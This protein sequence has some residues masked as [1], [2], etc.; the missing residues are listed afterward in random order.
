LH[1]PPEEI[2]RR[3]RACR[4]GLEKAHWQVLWL[5]TRPGNPLSPA[6]AAPQ[7]GL[8]AVWVRTLIKRWN[9]QGPDGLAD[10][11]AATN[12]GHCKLSTDQQ[13]DLWGALQHPPPDGGL[14][15]GSKVAAYVRDRWGVS[16]C[17]QTGWNWLRGLGFSLR[18]PRPRHPEAA[19]PAQ[20]RAWE[21]RPGPPARPVASAAS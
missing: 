7:V 15:T 18:V 2:A 16:L 4:S 21:R 11:R 12:G 17:V 8:S 5:V 1:L 9:A 3:Y 6:Q 13:I 14:W 19:T 20:Q 10:R